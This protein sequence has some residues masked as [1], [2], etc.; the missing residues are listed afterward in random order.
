MIDNTYKVPQIAWHLAIKDKLFDGKIKSEL[1]KE[2]FLKALNEKLT[3]TLFSAQSAGLYAGIY[4][5]TYQ[6]KIDLFGYSEKASLLLEEIIKAIKNLEISKSDFDIYQSSLQK[7]YLNE[8]K[9]LPV[10]QAT[11]YLFHILLPTN[12]TSVEKL[13]EL[14]Q[15]T[16]KDFTEFKNNILK[17]TYI[18]GFLTGNLTLKEAESVWFDIKDILGQKP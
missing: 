3:S 9:I 16:L 18:E 14:K 13:S 15:I 11:N 12:Y 10:F 4:S 7:N 8:Q 2:L 6:I 17:S 5:D 1:L